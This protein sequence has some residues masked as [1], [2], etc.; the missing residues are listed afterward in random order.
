MR[1]DER[2]R[3]RVEMMRC[4]VRVVRLSE[5]EKDNLDLFPFYLQH[6]MSPKQ[7]RF[8]VSTATAV[9]MKQVE[10]T[11]GRQR[12]RHRNEKENAGK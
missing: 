7:C 1:T 4:G 6:L 8:S 10:R 3:A 12:C 9:K 2:L 5:N 11:E